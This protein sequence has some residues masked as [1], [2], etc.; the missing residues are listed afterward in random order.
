MF[1]RGTAHGAKL[2]RLTMSL[3]DLMNDPTM[4]DDD[5]DDD[6]DDGD[7]NEGDE[8]EEEEDD[9]DDTAEQGGSTRSIAKLAALGEI[10][11][12]KKLLAEGKETEKI[13]IV[14]GGVSYAIPFD[15]DAADSNGQT[16]LLG[17]IIAG[18]EACAEATA[19][20]S[21]SWTRTARATP[22]K[23]LD[24]KPSSPL[25][26]VTAAAAGKG[27]EAAA[28]HLECIC[29]LLEGGADPK[30]RLFGRTAL[31]VAAAVAALP[32]ASLFGAR[33]TAALLGANASLDVA[34]ACGDTP[35]HYAAVT[36]GDPR[37]TCIHVHRRQPAP[38]LIPCPHPTPLATSGHESPTNLP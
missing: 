21:D 14:R 2:S 12:L 9:E 16:A 31:H 35:L 7:Y 4:D 28:T 20:K 10:D 26:A 17:A 25:A 27:A 13:T 5:D 30:R 24:D 8:E 36:R 11:E 19:K 15:I 37:N 18:A 1:L 34:D 32:A 29:A 6:D 22:E 3:A 23:L 38:A 33:V